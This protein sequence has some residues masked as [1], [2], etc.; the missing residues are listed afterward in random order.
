M[1]RQP[2]LDFGLNNN[3]EDDGIDSSSDE[4]TSNGTIQGVDDQFICCPSTWSESAQ[5]HLLTVCT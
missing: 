4:L 1:N 3:E 5:D 2:T